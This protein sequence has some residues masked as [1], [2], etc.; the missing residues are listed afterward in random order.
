MKLLFC[1]QFYYPSIGGVQEVMKQLAERLAAK[2]HEVTVA[3]ATH[4]RRDFAQLNGVSVKQFAVSGNRVQGMVGDVHAYRQFLRDSDADLVFFYAAQQ[5]SFDAAWEVMERIK[6]RK[7]LVPC[8][9][10]ALY[11]PTYREYFAELP[12]VLRKFDHLVYHALSYRDYAFGQEHGLLA[13]SLIPNGADDVEFSTPANSD[14]RKALGIGAEDLVL[15]TVGT[16]NG[17]KGH[18]ELAAAFRLA[19]FSGKSATLV[20]NANTKPSIQL[21]RSA[22]GMLLALFGNARSNGWAHTMRVVFERV[23]SR[24]GLKVDLRTELGRLAD[25]VRQE[26]GGSKRIVVCDL[27]RDELVQLY[28]GAD[29]FV[30]ASKIEYSPLVLFEACAAG[31]PFLSAPVGNAAEIAAWTGGGEIYSAEMDRKGFTQ[32]VPAVLAKHIETLMRDATRR[33]ALSDAGR[34]AWQ[35]RFNWK[36][37]TEEY[38]ALFLKLVSQ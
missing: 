26:S 23:L 20:L 35:R 21:P 16:L 34:E 1:V 22:S 3:T 36:A 29:L 7:V 25:V 33:R 6:G 19:D 30:F 13:A 28:L 11:V 32:S 10:S 27:P 15:M 31:L 12:G 2:G 4:E 8:G 14:F 5:W 17:M 9:Y 24:F 38:E 18:E 37:L